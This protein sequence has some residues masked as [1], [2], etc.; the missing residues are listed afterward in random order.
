MKGPYNSSQ[1]L[2]DSIASSNQTSALWWWEKGEKGQNGRKK[3]CCR[4]YSHSLAQA[5]AWYVSATGAMASSYCRGLSGQFI[6]Y[7]SG[8]GVICFKCLSLAVAA[9]S[10]FMQ[11]RMGCRRNH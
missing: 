7:V 5:T 1:R 2:W 9:A 4:Y 6:T 10:I 3:P 8:N 11:R